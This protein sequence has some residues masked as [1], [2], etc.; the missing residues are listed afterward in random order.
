MIEV[1]TCPACGENGFKTFLTCPDH[2]ISNEKFNL[3]Q[4]AHCGLVATSPRPE[5]E[6]LYRYYLSDVYTSHT[7]RAKNLLDKLY[8][9]ARGF[10]LKWKSSLVAR[11]TRVSGEKSILDFGCGTAQFL[12][13]MKREEWNIAG[14][15]PSHIARQNTHE[16]IQPV[17]VKSIDDLPPK[18]TYS[19]ITLWHVLEHVHDLDETLQALKERLQNDGTLF[20]AVPNHPCWDAKKY[21]SYWAGYDVPRHLWHFSRKSMELLLTKNNLRLIEIIPMRLD[22]I[23]VSILSEKYLLKGKLTTAKILKGAINGIRSNLSARKTMEYS[24]LIYVVKK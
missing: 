15:E 11:N 21:Q 18:K 24:S 6:D 20:I 19:A 7:R 2:S 8:I 16:S 22:A 3:K 23:Y 13:F 14:I 17:V 10:T 4:C 1:H 9:L 12:E 5:T